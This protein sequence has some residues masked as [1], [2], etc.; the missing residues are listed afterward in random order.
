M[1]SAQTAH[2][3]SVEA[4]ADKGRSMA[5]KQCTV[6]VQLGKRLREVREARRL[7]MQEVATW[8]GTTPQ[9]ISHL[10][11]GK[12]NIPCRMLAR[13]AAAYGI[14]ASDLWIGVVCNTQRPLPAAGG[15]VLVS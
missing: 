15:V 6:P 13:L 14:P 2:Y 5:S 9:N 12:V 4:D 10:E 1:Y 7:T 8:C 11:L 3:A